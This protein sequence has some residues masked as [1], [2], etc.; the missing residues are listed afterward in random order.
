[1]EIDIKIYE[2]SIS[3]ETGNYLQLTPATVSNEVELKIVIVDDS[4]EISIEAII[5]V[6]LK[7]L[8]LALDK[9]SL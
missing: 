5:G 9:L 2:H 7:D 8:R 3:G 6:D 1:M 4:K